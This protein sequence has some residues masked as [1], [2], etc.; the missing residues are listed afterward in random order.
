MGCLAPVAGDVEHGNHGGGDQQQ[1][2]QRRGR[3]Q[4]QEVHHCRLWRSRMRRARLTRA[5]DGR[6]PP[7]LR[8]S[9]AWA[10]HV[11]PR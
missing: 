5:D 3:W 4:V 6:G 2:G 7:G 1:A 11:H 8:P 10:F 9:F